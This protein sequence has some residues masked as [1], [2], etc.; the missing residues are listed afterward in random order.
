MVLIDAYVRRSHV[1]CYLYV[2]LYLLN[3]LH[4]L[5]SYV[6]TLQIIKSVLTI[7]VD[8]DDIFNYE[9]FDDYFIA[10]DD[11]FISVM[12]DVEHPIPHVLTQHGF[13]ESFI[14]LL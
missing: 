2:I 1:C 12:I 9:A 14:K 11:Y 3:C 4:I 8:N 10:F 7:R 6:H 5:P 13:V